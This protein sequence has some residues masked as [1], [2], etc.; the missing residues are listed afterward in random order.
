MNLDIL[1]ILKKAMQ[2]KAI[3]KNFSDIVKRMEKLSGYLPSM[4]RI[5][6]S[7]LFYLVSISAKQRFFFPPH[8]N[9]LM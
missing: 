3:L 2:S 1:D 8:Q 7:S 6:I 4:K 9:Q 5:L